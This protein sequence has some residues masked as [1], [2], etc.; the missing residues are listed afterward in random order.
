MPSSAEIV[1]VTES[2]NRD[3]NRVSVR[4]DLGNKTECG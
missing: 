2:M 1:A 3:L 4:C